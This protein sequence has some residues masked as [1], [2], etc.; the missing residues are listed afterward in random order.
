MLLRKCSF[1]ALPCVFGSTAELVC[2]VSTLSTLCAFITQ[3]VLQR[4]LD[5][6][7]WTIFAPTNRA[8]FSLGD[9]IAEIYDNPDVLSDVILYH[10]VNDV[11]Y[12]DSL[13]CAATLEMANGQ[14]STTECQD[15]TIYQKGEENSF[16]TMPKIVARNINACN[17][18]IH[19]VDEVMIPA[20]LPLVPATQSPP[21]CKTIGASPFVCSCV[22][23]QGQISHIPST[24]RWTITVL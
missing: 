24:E 11:L 12:S 3:S 4:T 17:G 10:A 16:A 9:R 23:L 7:N 20:D 8:F 6:G 5:E 21:R 13:P 19:I 15:G 22:V 14:T 18:V 1:S 2:R